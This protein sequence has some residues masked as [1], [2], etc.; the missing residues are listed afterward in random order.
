MQVIYVVR[1]PRDVCMS[2]LN[3]WRVIEGYFGDL[4]TFVNAFLDDACGYYTPFI[5]HVLGYWDARN[6]NNI[7]FLSYEGMKKD[8]SSVIKKVGAFLNKPVPDDK[9]TQLVDHL[10]FKNMK[11]NDMVNKSELVTVRQKGNKSL[12]SLLLKLYFR[13]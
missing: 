7:L 2:Y 12:A 11:T 8:L 13:P 4:Q 6:E 1:N 9:M 5:G 3:H 10:S